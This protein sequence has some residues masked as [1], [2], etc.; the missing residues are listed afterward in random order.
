MYSEEKKK[1]REKW[2][3]KACLVVSVSK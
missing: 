2:L 3:A 1:Q